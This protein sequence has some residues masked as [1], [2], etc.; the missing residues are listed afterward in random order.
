MDNVSL[1][2]PSKTQLVGLIVE[3]IESEIDDLRMAFINSREVVGTG[4]R[5]HAAHEKFPRKQ[6]HFE[7]F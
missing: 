1:G 5:K 7:E 6:I 3:R 2:S 4:F